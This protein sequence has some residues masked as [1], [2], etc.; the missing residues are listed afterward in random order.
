MQIRRVNETERAEF[1]QLV[2]AEIRPDHAKTNAWQDFPLIL[3]PKNR[4]NQLVCVTEE[5]HIAGCISC[6]IRENRTSC[7]VLRVAGVGSVVT[8]PDY[9]GKGLSTALQSAML[10]LI[11]GKNVPLAVLWTDQP[12]IYAGRG[13]TP[14]G[15]EIHADISELADSVSLPDGYRIREFHSDDISVIENLFHDHPLGTCRQPGDSQLLYTMGGT[16]GL[17]VVDGG[18]LVQASI[19][20]GKGADFPQYVA[21]W[22]GPDETV[23]PL[24]LAARERGLAQNVLIPPGRE[25]LVNPLVDLGASWQTINSGCWRIVDP[26]ALGQFVSTA[27]EKVPTDCSRATD[28]L[29]GVDQDGQPLVGPLTLAV[30]GFDSV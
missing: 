17:V 2:N 8:H 28:W 16:T 29:G 21:E 26:V 14:A 15:W 3:D 23:L 9:R 6:L 20:C 13:F 25:N 4:E 30:W 12:E 27:G 1:L 11:K 18:G 7:G 22:S 5:G 19:F 24:I 10:E